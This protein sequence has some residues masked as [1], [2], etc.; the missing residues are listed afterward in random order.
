MRFDFEQ[1]VKFERHF[2]GMIHVILFGGT[3]IA[4]SS[5]FL[6]YD[7]RHVDDKSRWNLYLSRVNDLVASFMMHRHVVLKLFRTR[8]R[9]KISDVLFLS[10][11][12]S[13]VVLLHLWSSGASRKSRFNMFSFYVDHVLRQM[14]IQDVPGMEKFQAK[15]S[16][17][18]FWNDPF[19]HV[20]VRLLVH[21]RI[22]F[23][24]PNYVICCKWLHC[25]CCNWATTDVSY[26]WYVLYAQLLYIGHPSHVTTYNL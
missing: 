16:V 23:S 2:V 26:V 5:W 22:V 12:T 7:V 9:Q 18:Y 3:P 20:F 25:G 17:C 4:L 1:L 8:M 10:F 21:A 19:V 14:A 13:N 15:I 11:P 24:A 6:M